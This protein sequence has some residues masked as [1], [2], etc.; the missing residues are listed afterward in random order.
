MKSRYDTFVWWDHCTGGDRVPES[1]FES[2]LAQLVAPMAHHRFA[3]KMTGGGS[4]QGKVNIGVKTG[5]FH[6][7]MTSTNH[8]ANR[9]PGQSASGAIPVQII[10]F[11]A[12]VLLGACSSDNSS[13]AGTAPAAY[14]SS[15][16]PCHGDGLG[17]APKTGKAA[18]WEARV[19]KGMS[20]V[21]RN[22]I[23][24]FEGGTG[25]MPAKG[26]R[27]DLSDDEITTLVDYM[28]EAS[29]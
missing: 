20:K 6:G 26:G 14:T 27:P 18:E 23:E 8:I 9:G 24:G 3:I 15:C 25:I 1:K 29:R 16:M 12:L 28:V 10:L 5:K 22:A 11:L 7:R 17:G 4:M 21:R 2:F 19:A 13:S